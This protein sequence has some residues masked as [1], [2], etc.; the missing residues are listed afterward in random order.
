M[1][2]T[3]ASQIIHECESVHYDVESMDHGFHT[4]SR[5]VHVLPLVYMHFFGIRKDVQPLWEILSSAILHII[6][7]R[8]SALL[9][10]IKLEPYELN[11]WIISC[12][13]W[14]ILWRVTGM[15]LLET[16]TIKLLSAI[17]FLLCE[18]ILKHLCPWRMAILFGTFDHQDG[19]SLRRLLMNQ[20]LLC[21]L[22]TLMNGYL[23]KQKKKDVSRCRAVH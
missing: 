23:F 11:W 2:C 6:S 3:L 18:K 21:K 9:V 19:C 12:W 17:N 14:L 5:S 1:E 10:F 7:G 8:L 4:N 20:K 22:F 15:V 16:H 13:T